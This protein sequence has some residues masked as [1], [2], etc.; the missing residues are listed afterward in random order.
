MA[1]PTGGDR[2]PCSPSQLYRDQVRL[3]VD[4]DENMLQL[5]DSNNDTVI[6]GDQLAVNETSGEVSYDRM[7]ELG[8][9]IFYWSLPSEFLG[10]KVSFV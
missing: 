5:I 6:H 4:S 7:Q 8:D 1:I 2:T 3:V 9:T 10:N